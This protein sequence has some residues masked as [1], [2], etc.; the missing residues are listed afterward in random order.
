MTKEQM[1][2]THREHK[3]ILQFIKDK[4]PEGEQYIKMHLWKRRTL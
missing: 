3:E 4:N 1:I 2:F